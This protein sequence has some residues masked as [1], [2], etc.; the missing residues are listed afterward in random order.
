M[1]LF[2]PFTCGTIPSLGF[3]TLKPCVMADHYREGNYST[4]AR[5]SRIYVYRRREGFAEQLD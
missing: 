4:E 5:H 1:V 3:W 2:D